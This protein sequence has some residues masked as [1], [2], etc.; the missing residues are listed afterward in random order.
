MDFTRRDFLARSAAGLAGAALLPD[1]L[2]AAPL[3]VKI[4]TCHASLETAKK[5]GIDGVQVGGGGAAEKLGI[6]DPKTIK[7]HK[8]QMAATGLQVCSIMMSVLNSNPLAEEPRSQAW[9]EQC[10]DAAKELGAKVILVAFFGKGDLSKGKD[11]KKEAVDAIIPKL[12]AVAPRAKDAGVILGLENTISA[13]QNLDIIE[14]VGS[15]AVGVYYD[16]YNLFHK[17]YD[18]AAEIRLLKD[19]I[20][21][22][23]FKNG[24]QYLGEGK[25]DWKAVGEALKAINYDKWIVLE[26]SN[27]SKDV[28]ADDRKNAEWI[29][30]LLA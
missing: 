21:E 25:I 3:K 5:A 23:H 30:Q 17:G 24:G 8:D 6:A 27:P 2:A 9:L 12:K 18:P 28:V 26:T 11:L 10:V 7:S 4:G 29:R 19:R 20:C 1:L 15:P 16:V 22:I 13:Q 14:R